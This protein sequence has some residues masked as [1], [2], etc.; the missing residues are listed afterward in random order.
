MSSWYS[1]GFEKSKEIKERQDKGEFE[2]LNQEKCRFWVSCGQ[3]REIIFL[4]D[5]DWKAE[6]N[7]RESVTVPFCRNEFKLDLNNAPDSWQDCVYLTDTSGSPHRCKPA[8]LK[9]KSNFVG[10]MTVLDV[11][12][13]T[14]R[15]TGQK[16]IRPRKKLLMA[17][18]SAA[19]IIETK[20]NKKGNLKGWKYSVSRHDKTD[21]RVGSDFEA[22][23][24][25]DDVHAF[26]KTIGCTPINLDPYGFTGDK[27]LEFYMDLF[28]PM[29]Y[30]DQENLF[31]T[32][33]VR[34]GNVFLAG[35]VD[36]GQQ[37]HSG[38]GASSD[39]IKY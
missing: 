19:A 13:V 1:G 30:E 29:P 4:D 36:S 5:F 32:Y 2:F 28:K 22:L 35:R 8:E 16:I 7:G 11:T 21:P 38:G 25:V 23:E 3:E 18:P 6:V 10:A 27:A 26:L 39:T 20:K 33:N 17:S 12:P 31:K 14:D 9:F 15:D 37:S 34:D 24:H